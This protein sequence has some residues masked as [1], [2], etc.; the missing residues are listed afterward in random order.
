MPP[1]L[2]DLVEPAP[3]LSWHASQATQPPATSPVRSAAAVAQDLW[4]SVYQALESSLTPEAIRDFLSRH[5]RTGLPDL[6]A[7]SPGR[8]G[9]QA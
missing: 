5:S 7:H 2:R 1:G 6:V 4:S 9:A 8:V 3:P